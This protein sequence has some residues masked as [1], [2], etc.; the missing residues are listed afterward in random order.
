MHGQNLCGLKIVGQ[1]VLGKMTLD[2]MLLDEICLDKSNTP[3]RI[4][5]NSTPVRYIEHNKVEMS[6]YA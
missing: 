4:I 1:K 3:L 5:L 2:E 6:L